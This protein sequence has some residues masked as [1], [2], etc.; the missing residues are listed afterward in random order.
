MAR[1]L[2]MPFVSS[3]VGRARDGDRH[4]VDP[5]RRA[6][7]WARWAVSGLEEFRGVSDREYVALRLPGRFHDPMGTG[8]VV[9]PHLEI[10]ARVLARPCPEFPVRLAQAGN[11]LEFPWWLVGE[12]TAVKRALFNFP[13]G[14]VDALVSA[15]NGRRAGL[16]HALEELSDSCSESWDVVESLLVT[17]PGALVDLATGDFEP[18]ELAEHFPPARE[19]QLR[20]LFDEHLRESNGK[21]AARRLG[22][23]QLRGEV[24]GVPFALGVVTP[25]LTPNSLFSDQLFTPALESPAAAMLRGALLRRISRELLSVPVPAAVGVDPGTGGVPGVHLR[26]VVA[27][28]GAKLPEA[29]VEAAVNFVHSYPDGR[30]AWAALERWAATG[31]L[32][33]VSEEAFL[34]GHANALRFIRRADTPPRDDI[35]VLLPLAWDRQ[36]RVVRVTF[37]RPGVHD[38]SAV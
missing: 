19:L 10:P 29:S 32:L 20:A 8:P 37:S 34:A 14:D 35:N 22:V 2:P 3:F 36:S 18:D 1:L 26:A 11:G 13:R 15:L 21:W 27:R 23:W 6:A 5:E 12:V 28:V 4:D 38:D 7:A 31:Y 30:D 25:R 33:T 9:P 16:V 24:D 17:D